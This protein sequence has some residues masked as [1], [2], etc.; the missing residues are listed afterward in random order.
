VNNGYLTLG[1]VYWL[2]STAFATWFFCDEDYAGR[3]RNI[4]LGNIIEVSFIGWFFLPALLLIAA[5]FYI[6]SIVIVRR[7]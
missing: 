1:I 5:Y 4:T 7:T 2:L 6:T 3:K